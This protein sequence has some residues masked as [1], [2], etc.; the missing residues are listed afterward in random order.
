MLCMRKRGEN[1]FA[2]VG[3]SGSVGSISYGKELMSITLQHIIMTAVNAMVI[4]L[5]LKVTGKG[6]A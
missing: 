5:L 4:T 6:D 2:I 1:S 3:I